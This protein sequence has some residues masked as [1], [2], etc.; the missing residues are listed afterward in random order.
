MLK[1]THFEGLDIL[2]KWT[3]LLVPFCA[4]E[5]TL[6]STIDKRVGTRDGV[7]AKMCKGVYSTAYKFKLKRIMY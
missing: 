2:W 6:K 5:Y 4:M 3:F 1:F 7:Y